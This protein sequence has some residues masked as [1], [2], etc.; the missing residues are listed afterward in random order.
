MQMLR[1][2]IEEIEFFSAVDGA[3]E[4]FFVGFAIVC[5]FLVGF[6]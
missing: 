4:F 5:V 1:S 3:V 2:Y 6:V